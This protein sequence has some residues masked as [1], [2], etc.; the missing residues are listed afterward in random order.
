MIVFLQKNLISRK[1]VIQYLSLEK[2]KSILICWF[3]NFHFGIFLQIQVQN[4]TANPLIPYINKVPRCEKLNKLFTGYKNTFLQLPCNL[5]PSACVQYSISYRYTTLPVGMFQEHGQT[6]PTTFG[7]TLRRRDRAP[8]EKRSAV[9][10]CYHRFSG[11]SLIFLRKPTLSEDVLQEQLLCY[12]R[13]P[14]CFPTL[15]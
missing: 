13:L 8:S 2:K 3:Q 6:N 9:R 7:G 14:K 4:M 15:L 12:N 10:P 5:E 11:M 1:M